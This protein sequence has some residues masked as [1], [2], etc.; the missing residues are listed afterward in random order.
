MGPGQSSMSEWTHRAVARLRS[1]HSKLLS[2]GALNR[3]EGPGLPTRD[4]RRE[5][6]GLFCAV[7][8]HRAA[9]IL[10]VLGP[11]SVILA[12]PSC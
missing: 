1:P 10:L 2:V 6:S 3:R 5:G 4:L 9:L 11:L 8:L 12:P 7:D